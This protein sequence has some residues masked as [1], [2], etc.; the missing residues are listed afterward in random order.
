MLEEKK[1][2]L[3][4]FVQ[5]DRFELNSYVTYLFNQVKELLP[6]QLEKKCLNDK[7]TNM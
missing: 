6:S 7:S 2:L 4:D 3:A 5:E 1:L